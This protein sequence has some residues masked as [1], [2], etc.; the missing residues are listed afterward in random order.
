MAASCWGLDGKGLVY[1]L[2]VG[3][4]MVV[5]I[6]VM[7]MV[8]LIMFRRKSRGGRKT[9]KRNMGTLVGRNLLERKTSFSSVFSES[10]VVGNKTVG[11]CSLLS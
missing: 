3:N 1:Q 11:L 6:T 2:V 9:R 7:M 5:V 8:V 4:G 10:A